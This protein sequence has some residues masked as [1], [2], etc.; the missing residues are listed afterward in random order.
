MR[1]EKRMVIGESSA[2]ARPER[3]YRK[4]IFAAQPRSTCHLYK[5]GIGSLM[6]AEAFDE[7]LTARSKA[8]AR[9]MATLA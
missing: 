5:T 8:V 4:P 9:H 7:R 6:M 1:P 2:R 3:P